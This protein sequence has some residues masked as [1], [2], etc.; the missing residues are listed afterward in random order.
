M[1]V[2]V[3]EG[4]VSPDE[5]YRAAGPAAALPHTEIPLTSLRKD[6]FYLLAVVRSIDKPNAAPLACFFVARTLQSEYEHLSQA[7]TQ[8]R[9]STR[10]GAL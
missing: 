4:T 3:Q 6:S 2:E 8:L 9:F 10:K 1:R 7:V 5:G